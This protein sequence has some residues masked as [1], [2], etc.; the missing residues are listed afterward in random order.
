ML[1]SY[2]WK[3]RDGFHK[4]ITD[5]NKIILFATNSNSWYEKAFF[6]FSHLKSSKVY[7]FTRGAQIFCFDSNRIEEV[8][9]EDT[10][11]Y[12]IYKQFFDDRSVFIK[13]TD[14]AALSNEGRDANE[15]R[16]S[17]VNGWH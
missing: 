3:L 14:A 2:I 5:I 4:N 16:P 1:A 17:L 10:M 8:A 15:K 6:T 7:S 12:K 9:Y 11:H 13:H